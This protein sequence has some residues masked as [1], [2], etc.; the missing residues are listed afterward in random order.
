M[1]CYLG[2]YTN[3]SSKGIYAVDFDT[4][5]GAFGEPR[6][7]AEVTNPTFVAVHPSGKF[8]YA[9][10]EVDDFGGKKTGAVAAYTVDEKSGDLQLINM[11]DA[12][13]TAT[14]SVAFDLSNRVLL[15]ANYSSGSVASFRIL[16]TGDLA[17]GSLIQ[18]FGT[19]ADAGRQS[20]PHAHCLFP[21]PSGKFALAC[22][23][24]TDEVFIY[25]IDPNNGTLRPHDPAVAKITPAGGGPRHIAFSPNGKF[26]YVNHEMG[27]KV[28]AFA[29]DAGDGQLT[30]LQVISTLP[31]GFD[32]K[33]YTSEIIVAPSGKFLYVSNRGHDSLAIF[34]IDA[35]S[36]KL[37]PTGHVST[38]GNFPRNFVIDPTGRYI[39]AAN[40]NS[41]SLIVFNMN[42]DTGELTPNG[43][44]LA[45]GKPVCIRFAPQR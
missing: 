28:T 33:S 15:V 31:D 42:P 19:S 16:D 17:S 39:I 30:E 45:I 5:A 25:K 7:V 29:W 38:G 24:G 43:K 8:L 44:T 6:L 23:L 27:N 20:G 12:G 35:K 2:T 40:Q 22:D 34:A 1:R 41:D 26:A 37:T 10:S 36:G 14:C 4:T 9:C 3:G 13:G 18:H 11:H 21:D 32:G